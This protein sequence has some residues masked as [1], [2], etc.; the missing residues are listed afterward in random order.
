LLI[1]EDKIHINLDEK[2][3]IFILRID[4][5]KNEAADTPVHWMPS[6]RGDSLIILIVQIL[7]TSFLEK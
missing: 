3:G 7:Y 5:K 1:L 2:V 4:T 6:L